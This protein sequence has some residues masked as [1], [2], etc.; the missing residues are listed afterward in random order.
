MLLETLLFTAEVTLPVCVMLL[1]GILFKKKGVIDDHFISVSS[2]LVFNFALPAVIFLSLSNLDRSA[3]LDPMLIGLAFSGSLAGFLLAW[4]VSLRVTEKRED[5]GVF[6]QGAA[7]GNLAIIGLALVANMY[8]DPGVALMS[9]MM[10]FII[11]LFNVCSVVVLGIY[12]QQSGASLSVRGMILDLV[13]NPLIIAVVLGVLV[14]LSGVGIPLV[15]DKV[16][17]YFAQISLPLALLGIGGTL[18]I[19]ALKETSLASLW[20]SLLK[21]V[22]LPLIVVPL[23]WG[24]G[25]DGMELSVIFLL[26]SCPTAVASFVMA[27]AFNGNAPLA[28]NI[29]VLTTLGSLPVVSVGIF[30]MRSV[31]V[32]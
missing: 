20:A 29:I 12:S 11:P 8:G 5:R 23:A 17:R 9:L 13:R 14:S 16:G 24:M 32:V 30:F 21:V 22:W 10:A 31:G 7:R 28:A 15:V 6:I 3:G 18:S 4:V 27:K 25:Y 26:F 2:R 19:Q 1:A